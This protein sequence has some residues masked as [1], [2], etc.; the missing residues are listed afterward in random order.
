M[1]HRSSF[2]DFIAFLGSI[3]GDI[4]NITAPP[5]FLAPLSVVELPSCWTE[6]P[7]LFIA[8]T[9]ESDPQNRALRVLEWILCSLKSQFYIGQDVK[10]GMRKPL[11][12]FL[13]ELFFGQWTD[14]ASAVR[15]ISEQVSHHPP[16]TACY[17]WDDQHGIRGIGY[18]RVEMTFTGSLNVKQTGHAILHLDRHDEDYLIPFPP[19]KVKGFLSG[20]LY[21][22]LYGTC[23]I[24]SSAGF[25]SEIT[26]SGQGFFSGT[27]N[28]FRAKTYRA[29]DENKTPIYLASGQWSDNFTIRNANDE[30]DVVTCVV[31]PSSAAPLQMV[32]ISNQDPWESRNTWKHV[33]AALKEGDIQKVVREKTKLEEAQRAMRKKESAEGAVWEPKFFSSI[34]SDPTFERLAAT[35]GWQLHA[36]RTKGIWRFD[37]EKAGKATKPYRG[38]YTPFG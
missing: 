31:D 20:K 2:K 14:E 26:F 16:I 23:H 33:I 17:M 27:R 15:M 9:L 32:D 38:N 6:R 19:C 37:H 36:E 1:E 22:E 8:P 29:A 34:Q 21:P 10:V 25:V 12:A 7:S 3:R 24:I 5:F 30:N 35:T 11:N 13:G 28:H 18:T 4:A